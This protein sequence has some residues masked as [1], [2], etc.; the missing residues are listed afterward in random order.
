MAYTVGA[1]SLGCN[2]NRV[3]TETALG[4]L[5]EKGFLLTDDPAKADI[6]LVNTCGF[7]DPAKEESVNTILEMAQYKISG[8][9]KVLVV[10]GCLSQRYSGDLMEEIPE[11]D[12]LLG[13]NQY[14]ELPAAINKALGAERPCLCSD[15]YGYYEHDRVLT[16]PSYSAYIRIGEGCSNRCTFCAI[17]M[18]RGPYRSRNE[19]AILREIR[20]LACSGVREHILVAQ[21]TTRYGTED[22]PHTT[23]PDLMK[24]AAAIDGVDWLRVLYCYP[25]ETNDALLDVLA[26]VDNVCPYLDIPVQHINAEMLKRMHRRGTREDILRCVRGARERGLTL[27]TTLIVGFPGETEDQ[28]RELMDFV[29]K[30]EFDRLGAFAYSPEEGTPAA[31]MPDQIPDEIKQE[32]LDRLMTLQQKI[33][34]KRNKA[35]I[36]SVEQV[37]VTDTDGKGNILGR[38]CREAPETDGEIY[39]SCGD[40]RPQPGQ[41]IPVQIL[42]AEEYDLRGKML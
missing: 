23:L 10:T 29:E 32:R 19:E 36:G 28:F 13:V 26:D 7:I 37:L 31:K 39:V 5:K 17:P 11:I 16:T 12:V 41:F 15:D 34:L 40:A 4:L 6:L 21:D 9:C 1:V 30:T 3:D 35:R 20:S 18:I 33:S 14:A 25:D 24:K 38:S 42:S 8:R 22:H 2:K 27:R